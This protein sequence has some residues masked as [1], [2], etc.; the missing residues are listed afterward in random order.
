MLGGGHSNES[1]VLDQWKEGEATC[2]ARP[3]QLS[4]GQKGNLQISLEYCEANLLLHE[5]ASI[6]SH[7]ACNILYWLT[8]IIMKQGNERGG[9]IM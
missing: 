5:G 8:L 2:W 1:T 7:S 9:D 3:T 4:V 6:T